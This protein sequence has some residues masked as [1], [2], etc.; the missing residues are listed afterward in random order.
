MASACLYCELYRL[1]EDEKLIS[2]FLYGVAKNKYEQVPHLADDSRHRLVV[3]GHD[4]NAVVCL[5]KLY[6]S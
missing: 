4:K 5:V 2:P 3:V 6:S 1:L